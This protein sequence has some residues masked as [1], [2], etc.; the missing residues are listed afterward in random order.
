MFETTVVQ[1]IVG[2]VDLP[3]RLPEPPAEIEHV[4][5][6]LHIIETVVRSVEHPVLEKTFEECL[7]SDTY[8]ELFILEWEGKIAGYGLI[9]KTFSQEAGGMV[10]WLEELYILEE[11]RSKGLGSEYF[12]YMEE[13]KEEGVT[14][15]RLEVEKE[16]E[17]AW[18]LYKRQG[19]DWLEYD[20]MI[21]EF[22]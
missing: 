11:Y 1:D 14:R 5:R 2:R 9:A 4:R 19:Y 3:H 15:F 6:Q 13:H 12:R 22:C 8:A 17:R 20:Q 10:Y 16:N 21:K 18:K 7:K